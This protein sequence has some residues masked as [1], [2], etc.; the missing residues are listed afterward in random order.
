MILYPP[1]LMLTELKPGF[2]CEKKGDI[3]DG[4]ARI[5]EQYTEENAKIYLICQQDNESGWNIIAYDTAPRSYQA[6]GFSLGKPYDDTDIF[7]ENI[8]VED[9]KQKLANFDYLYLSNV[10]KQFI[11]CYGEVFPTLNIKSQQVYKIKMNNGI[12][13]LELL[14]P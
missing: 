11:S 4:D 3:Y 5:I 8:S 2:L 6:K 10:D 13:K 9:W 12:L 14:N 7:T 1:E